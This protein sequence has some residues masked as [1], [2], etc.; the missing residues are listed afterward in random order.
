MTAAGW[1]ELVALALADLAGAA[2]AAQTT[3]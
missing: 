3:S 1:L 2:L